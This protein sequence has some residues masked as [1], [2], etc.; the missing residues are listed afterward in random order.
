MINYQF[1]L[2]QNLKVKA[3]QGKVCATMELAGVKQALDF[4][5]YEKPPSEN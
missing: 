1:C 2:Q 3:P 5:C 4:K